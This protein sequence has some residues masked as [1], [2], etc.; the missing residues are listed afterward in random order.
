MMLEYLGIFSTVRLIHLKTTLTPCSAKRFESDTESMFCQRS[1]WTAPSESHTYDI[2]LQELV[3]LK[4]AHR[5]YEDYKYK[6]GSCK[7][8][9][10]VVYFISTNKYLMGHKTGQDF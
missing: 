5:F 4:E 1:V 6:P 7:A 9:M 8:I 3:C 2:D 10:C